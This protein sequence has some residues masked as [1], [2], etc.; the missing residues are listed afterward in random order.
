MLK[1]A[2][3]KLHL[4]Y[5]TTTNAATNTVSVHLI[6]YNGSKWQRV[7]SAPTLTP[8]TLLLPKDGNHLFV[9][10][11]FAVYA[12][13]AHTGNTLWQHAFDQPIWTSYLLDDESLLIHLELSVVCLDVDGRESWRFNHND[14]ITQ[15]TVQATH[16]LVQDFDEQQF[17]LDKRTGILIPESV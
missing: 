13:D 11:S 3:E 17:V 10:Y 6:G 4:E 5:Y 2:T 7:L 16:L 8:P 15:V 9:A 14:I 12:L 1:L